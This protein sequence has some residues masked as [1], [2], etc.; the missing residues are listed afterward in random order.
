MNRFLQVV[1]GALALVAMTASAAQAADCDRAC[2][3]GMITTYV[4][5]MVAHDP[6]RLP[7]AAN[8][9]FTED[10]QD[11]KPGEGLWK[12]VTKKGDF[13]QDYIDA[14]KQIAASHV[15][16]FEDN[17]TVLYSVVLRVADQKI[18]GIET[19]V[20]RLMPNSRFKPDSLEKPL[21][22]M[23]APVPAGKRMPRAEMIAAALRYPEGLRIGNF[24]DAKTPFSKEAYRVENGMFIAGEGGP[25]PNAPGLFTQK[26]MLHPDV[27]A[28][29]AAVDEE[30]G[31][32]L[33]WMNFGDTNS[34]GP[35]NAL[36]TFE[37]FKVWGGEIHAINAFFRILPKETQRGW[38]SAE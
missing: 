18:T 17:A 28:S 19:L 20:D 32:V 24:T 14:K 22:G 12:T 38:P 34:Y 37:A 26:I 3:K 6:A 13:R 15:M 23:S 8:A 31:I 33:L 11:L 10:S 16:L 7:L 21:G 36:V 35:G 9:R 29:V 30:E 2:L 27:K 25:R 4:D 1:P 5:A